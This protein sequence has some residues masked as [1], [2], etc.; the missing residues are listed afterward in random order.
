MRGSTSRVTARLDGFYQSET[1]NAVSTSPL[2]AADLDG[3]AIFNAVTT[4]S[5]DDWDFSLWVKNIGNEEGVT[6][7]Y[8]EAYMGTDPGNNYYGNG[9]KELISLPRTFGATVA[10]RF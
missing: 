8:T 7:I 1:R 5:R 9:S 2:F 6:G 10:L 3:F 4:L